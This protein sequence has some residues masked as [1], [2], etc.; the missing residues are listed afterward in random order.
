MNTRNRFLSFAVSLS[1]LFSMNP[2]LAATKP[3]PLPGVVASDLSKNL[4]SRSWKCSNLDTSKAGM[5]TKTFS[6]SSKDKTA[7][8]DVWGTS[9]RNVTWISVKANSK[10]SYGWPRFISTLPIDGVDPAGAQKWVTSALNAKASATKMF[11]DIKFSVVVGSGISRTL[12]IGHKNT[13]QP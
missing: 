5:N 11:G 10:I 8:V 13:I 2:A 1:I 12:T 4:E 6:C 7:T 9:A 3:Q